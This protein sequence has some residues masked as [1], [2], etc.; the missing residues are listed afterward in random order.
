MKK[1]IIALGCLALIFTFFATVMAGKDLNNCTTIQSGELLTSDGSLI[2]MRYDVKLSMKWNYAWLSN[3]DCDGDGKLD[4][5]CRWR[6]FID[7]LVQYLIEHN[8]EEFC[9][10]IVAIPADATRDGAANVGIWYA[11]DG[12]EIGPDIWGEFTI[13]QQIENTAYD[14]I[15]GV[16][17]LSPVGPR[18]GKFD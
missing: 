1:F 18:L 13:I 6:Y 3:K 7:K 14:G 4:R 10:K 9:V 2:E 17:Y 11:A 12:T 15:H 16:Q 8:L 5:H